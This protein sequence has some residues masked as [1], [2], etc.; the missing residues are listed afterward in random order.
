MRCLVLLI[1]IQQRLM[2]NVI[3]IEVVK[4]YQTRIYVRSEEHQWINALTKKLTIDESDMKQL[5][6]AGYSFEWVT[7]EDVELKKI[8]ELVQA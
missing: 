4:T 3:Q 2:N 5:K 1:Q 8:A 7:S 6:K